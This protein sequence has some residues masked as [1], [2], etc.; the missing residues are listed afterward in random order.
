MPVKGGR[1]F[2]V[3]A[4]ASAV[5]STGL[6]VTTTPTI[7]TTNSPTGTQTF[8]T[9]NTITFTTNTGNR[10]DMN[11][12]QRWTNPYV[13][14]AATGTGTLNG[15]AGTT[16]FI[17]G[18]TSG[19]Y[20]NE[21]SATS[22]AYMKTT[23]TRG[24]TVYYKA[25]KINSSCS[26]TFN[27]TV[28]ANSLT[29]TVT[30]EY[31]TS[32]GVYGSSVSAGTVSSISSVSATATNLSPGTYYF[33]IKAVNLAG[34]VYGSEQSV[35]VAA[36]SVTAST[37]QS[38]T[39]PAVTTLYEVLGV[40]AGGINDVNNGGGGSGVGSFDSVTLGSFDY[41]TCW[42]GVAPTNLGVNGNPN[43]D[44]F[45]YVFTNSED[46]V[47]TMSIIPGFEGTDYNGF[48][49]RS[50]LA[51]IVVSQEAGGS[52]TGKYESTAYDYI[53]DTYYNG[54]TIGAGGS[55][56]GGPGGTSSITVAGNGGASVTRFGITVASG[57]GGRDGYTPDG[58]NNGNT[59][60]SSY[61]G[62]GGVGRPVQGGVVRF[63]YYGP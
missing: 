53:Y 42:V 44:A 6:D 56:A 2:D 63:K 25:K 40:A 39:P 57:G 52:F 18:T 27:G 21:V 12:W 28:R 34:T 35:T 8:S 54:Q 26:A 9:L 1:V 4:K 60:A 15:S 29:T 17:W 59:P 46:D 7:P 49:G 36:T 22:N 51:S 3:G 43:E 13:L 5:T 19:S 50:G 37:E 30:F 32:S 33:R 61:G 62:G 24:T 14:R 11:S 58:V 48:G 47:M 16:H 23:W 10:N 41:L 20:P 45:T 38:F 31:G 55:G